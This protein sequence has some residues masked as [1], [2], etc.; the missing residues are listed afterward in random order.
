MKVTD[1]FFKQY[2]TNLSFIQN[3]KGTLPHNILKS[4][5]G[6]GRVLAL[7]RNFKFFRKKASTCGCA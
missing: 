2:G 1:R 3:Q 6:G 5:R 4:D 7:L